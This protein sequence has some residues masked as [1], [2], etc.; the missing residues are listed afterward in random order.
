MKRPLEDIARRLFSASALV[1]LVG[2]AMPALPSDYFKITVLDEATGRGVPLVELKTTHNVPYFTD[3]SGLVA[4]SE[5][6]LMGRRVFFFL[7]SH[8]YE[9]SKDGFGNVGVALD[10]RP[11]GSATLKLKRAN[12]AERLYRVTG[13]GTYRDS[14]LLGEPVPVRH[15]LLNAEVLGQDSVQ[16]A[17]YRGR[18]YWFWGD[19]TR[20]SYPLGN[21]HTS[22]A[23]SDLPGRGGLDPAVG[24]DL[25]YFTNRDDFVKPMAPLPGEGMVWLDGLLTVPDETG[26]ERLVAH[27]SR[28]KSLGERLEHGLVIFNDAKEE[29]E[30][31]VAFDNADHWRCPQNQSIRVGDG[32]ADWFYFLWPD[33]PVRVPADLARLKNPASYEAFTCVTADAPDSQARTNVQRDAGGKLVWAWRTNA[34]PLSTPDERRL[35]EAGKLSEAEARFQFRDVDT[36]KRVTIHTGAVNWNTFRNQWIMV[37][38]QAGGSSFL[39]EVWYAEAASPLGPWT[40][41][42]KIVT[43]DRYSFYNPAHHP[44]LDQQGGRLIYFEGTYAN[45]FSGN[46]E[47]T[48]RYDYNQI[49][50]RLDL[51]DPRLQLSPKTAP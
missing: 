35:L 2:C 28:M 41:A 21:F 3:N 24:V 34:V 40:S 6:G 22:G 5:P 14:A 32:G 36:G 15:P 11:G 26:R 16:A 47:A 30:K 23:T 7:R 38:V 48:P 4:F 8:G 44:F 27:Y 29:F 37:G 10:V 33:R 1:V 42:R 19:T 12:I 13:A 45:T 31:L 39:G 51:A 20:A 50:Y 18:L 46:P 43:H 9:F 25:A 17:P 49:M